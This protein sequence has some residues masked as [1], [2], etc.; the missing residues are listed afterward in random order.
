MSKAQVRVP[1]HISTL[2]AR[3]PTSM[4][5]GSEIPPPRHPNVRSLHCSRMQAD[6]RVRTVSGRFVDQESTAETLSS[7]SVM[8]RSTQQSTWLTSRQVDVDSRH[9]RQCTFPRHVYSRSSCEGVSAHASV[10]FV[11]LLMYNQKSLRKTQYSTGY[12]GMY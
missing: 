4:D 11:S 7:R 1:A 3:R 9:G 10:T 12:L 5:E 2:C 6:H 8:C